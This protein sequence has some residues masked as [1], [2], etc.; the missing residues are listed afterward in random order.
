MNLELQDIQGPKKFGI[1]EI[2]KCS[3]EYISLK[4]SV[5]KNS[6]VIGVIDPPD[7][8][9]WKQVDG[10]IANQNKVPIALKPASGIKNYD[11]IQK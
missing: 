9:C 4:K 7:F 10:T 2:Q 1:K 5:K 11:P 6:D 3:S 8:V